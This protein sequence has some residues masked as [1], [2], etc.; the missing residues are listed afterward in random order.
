M[1][2]TAIKAASAFLRSWLPYRFAQ[3]TLPCL[4]VAVSYKNK[5][6][7]SQNLGVADSDSNQPLTGDHLFGISSQSK[8]FTAVALMQLCEQGKLHL[9]DRAC[10]HLRWLKAHPQTRM[11]E[12][13]LRQL[14]IHRSG[15]ARDL[16]QSDFWTLDRPFPD[17]PKLQAALLQTPILIEPN[18]KLKY[19]NAG[20][21]LLGMVI[22][23]VSGLSFADYITGNIIQKLGLKNTFPDFSP[24]LNG[25]TVTGYGVPYKNQRMPLG[26]RQ[27]ARA[28]A[29]VA[30]IHSTCEDMCTFVSALSPGSTTL[31]SNTS[32][33]EM[34][35]SHAIQTSG[36]DEGMGFGMGFEILQIG[37][38]RFVGHS[39]HL[40]GHLT[41]TY[42]DPQTTLTVS[43]A[44]S[45]KD[46][47]SP[48]IATGIVEAIGFFAE[49]ATRRTP[50]GSARFNTRL[51]SPIATVEIVATAA[52]TVAIDPDDW[53]PFACYETLEITGKDSLRITTEGSIFNEGEAVS[54][55]F[56]DGQVASAA[57]AGGVLLPE[58][59]Y[60]K[61]LVDSI[62][63]AGN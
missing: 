31:L 15:L 17:A 23:A 42:F 59:A 40:A 2:T 52:G 7:F 8:M 25:R 58:R 28:F 33:K 22:E 53:Q 47:P 61:T 48:Q 9:D 14:L 51:F 37:G 6:I 55:I 1:N 20:Y 26:G 49:S 18:T 63:K 43:V 16:P 50:P 32:R 12:V 41:A 19:S 38:Q 27:P 57:Y 60:K 35:R 5:V 54:Y 29:A 21:A 11:R 44:G 56:R 39:G 4:S 46:T 34:Q 3:T 30:G 62:K 10:E 36:Y 45:S 13:T 24:D